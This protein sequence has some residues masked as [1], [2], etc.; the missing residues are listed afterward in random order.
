M[1]RERTM[2]RL[3]IQV[4]MLAFALGVGDVRMTVLTGLM[5]CIVDGA[6]GDFPERG[7]TIVP[8]LAKCFGDKQGAYRQERNEAG[9]E[10]GG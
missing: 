6:C 1:L 7:S 8:V 5:A 9:E 3:A 2:A 10:Y 4:G